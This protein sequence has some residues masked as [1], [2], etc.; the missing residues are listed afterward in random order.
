MW[1]QRSRTVAKWGV[2]RSATPLYA[3]LP[4][5]ESSQK[6]PPNKPVY[7]GRAL[8]SLERFFGLGLTR[9]QYRCQLPV[10]ALGHNS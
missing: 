3:Q 1:M 10:R 4:S 7:Q 6:S 2:G 5:N 8:F 9:P